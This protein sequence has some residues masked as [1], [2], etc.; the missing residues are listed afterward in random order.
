METTESEQKMDWKTKAMIGLGACILI[1]PTAV[2]L[3]MADA[4]FRETC[5]AGCA[6][7]GLSYRVE[8]VGYNA[9]ARGDY[10]AKCYCISREDRTVWEKIRDMF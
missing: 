1:I 2:V 8:N 5:K 6:P 10:P 3:T 4:A 7:N 9:G